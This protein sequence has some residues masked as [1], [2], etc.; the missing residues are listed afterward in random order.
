MGTKI[1]KKIKNLKF[2]DARKGILNLTYIT[3]SRIDGSHAS[4]LNDKKMKKPTFKP[5]YSS[6]VV[7]IDGNIQFN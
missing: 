7:A 5:F 2:F 6:V 3:T 1:Q 4:K